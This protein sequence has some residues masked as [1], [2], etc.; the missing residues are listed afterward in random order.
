[1]AMSGVVV[2]TSIEEEREYMRDFEKYQHDYNRCFH[3]I[4]QCIIAYHKADA[5]LVDLVSGIR[6]ILE[7]NDISDLTPYD[8]ESVTQLMAVYAWRRV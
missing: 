7:S 6:M 4:M 3:D 1:M 5:R 2:L 8:W